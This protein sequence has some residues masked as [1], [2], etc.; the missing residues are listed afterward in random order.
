M[1]EEDITASGE[2]EFEILFEKQESE[3]T[4]EPPIEEWSSYLCFLQAPEQNEKRRL[5]EAGLYV[6]PSEDI[7][8]KYIPLSDSSVYRHP[9]YKYPSV[10]DPGIEDAL[11]QPPPEIIYPDDGQELYKAVCKEMNEPFSR[12]FYKQL[13]NSHMNMAYYGISPYGWRPMAIALK[14]NRI[15][16]SINF[17]SNFISVDGCYHFG[18]MLRENFTITEL[19]FTGCRMGP[20]GMKNLVNNFRMNTTL[21]KLNVGR[22]CLTDAGMQYLCNVLYKG[23]NV[24]NIGL[25]YNG[26]SSVSAKNLADAIEFMNII[27]HLDLSYNN[28]TIPKPVE[29]LMSRFVES[30]YFEEINL[31][32]NSLTNRFA[33]SLSNLI[34]CPKI[35]VVN[36]SN[37][38]LTG[39]VIT[40]IA[41]NL[42]L[43][44]NLNTLD[45]SFNPLTIG[46]AKYVLNKM[47]LRRVKINELLMDNVTVDPFFVNLK[48]RILGFKFRK[49]AVITHGYVVPKKDAAVPDLREIVFRRA[50][51]L[52]Q[53][54][55]KKKRKDIAQ[56]ILSLNKQLKGEP[57][58]V[59]TLNQALNNMGVHHLNRDLV[60]AL[61]DAFP[62]PKVGKIIPG[63][64]RAA[65]EYVHRLWPDAK[66][67]D[68][69][70]KD[71]D[72]KAKKDK[73]AKDKAGKG[74]VTK[75]KPGKK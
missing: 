15:V 9:Y 35:R 65:A 50:D 18:D 52:C 71:R 43:A 53:K 61:V 40:L 17:A 42:V 24:S 49:D 6:P 74:T 11:L 70:P 68:I 48:N 73:A 22:N 47:R 66:L 31:S 12:L 41:D 32:W 44:K 51:Y 8:A 57:I 33:K 59:N 29:T 2:Q 69:P 75:G 16:H 1:S 7:C 27:T 21:R 13:L 72:K 34:L 36:L 4:I 37:N 5:F 46:E 30:D 38:N 26:L 63:N 58:F 28:F 23:S 55:P 10:K 64:M 62:G 67:S 25:S 39:N 45:L 54:G 19:D 3:N 14:K 20:V 56:V 60:D